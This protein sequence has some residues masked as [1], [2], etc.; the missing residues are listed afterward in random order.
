MERRRFRLV[1]MIPSFTASFV[2]TARPKAWILGIWHA[3]RS[4]DFVR[5]NQPL[6]EG[7][8]TRIKRDSVSTETR[9][10]KGEEACTPSLLCTPKPI[11]LTCFPHFELSLEMPFR[12]L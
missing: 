7:K 4:N 8:S 2:Q 1:A 6:F 5:V 11:N 10:K 9:G 3:R 12:A